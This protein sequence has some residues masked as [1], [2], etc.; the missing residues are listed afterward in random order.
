MRAQHLDDA[1]WF[2]R[3]DQHVVESSRGDV[4]FLDGREKSGEGDNRYALGTGE[5]PQLGDEIESAHV[6]QDDVLEDEI[7]RRC[8]SALERAG[9][10]IRLEHAVAFGLER[11]PRHLAGDGIVFDDEDGRAHGCSRYDAP[12][13]GRVRVS[14][15]FK[16]YPSQP[17]ANARSSSPFMAHAVGA[18]ILTRRLAARADAWYP[19]PAPGTRSPP[20]R[21]HAHGHDPCPA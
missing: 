8:R 11:D 5:T 18:M 6:R 2:G 4:A 14:I 9:A 7:G 10:R 1:R 15:G 20:R 19:P 16:M 3:F 17:A 12:M 13:A 21:A